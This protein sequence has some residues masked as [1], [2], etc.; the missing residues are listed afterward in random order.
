MCL[1]ER[2]VISDGVVVAFYR[3]IKRL[4]IVTLEKMHIHLL[5]Y[6]SMLSTPRVTW[7]FVC[8]SNEILIFLW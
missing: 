6:S 2:F 8:I 4:Q 7:D 3:G 1:P 5:N